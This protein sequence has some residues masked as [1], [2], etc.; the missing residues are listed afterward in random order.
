[1]SKSETEKWI[2]I[3]IE[4]PEELKTA[5]DHIKE[6]KRVVKATLCR[7][8]DEY[9]KFDFEGDF[10]TIFEFFEIFQ[11]VGPNL[12]KNEDFIKE[13]FPLCSGYLFKYLD[14]DMRNSKQLYLTAL[15]YSSKDYIFKLAQNFIKE[16]EI[17]SDLNS[18][19]D[20]V[21]FESFLLNGMIL[22]ETDNDETMSF[23]SEKETIL[24]AL[25]YQPLT[26]KLIN[27]TLKLDNDI[28]LKAI[29]CFDTNFYYIPN[30]LRGNLEIVIAYLKSAVKTEITYSRIFEPTF[31]DSIDFELRNQSDLYIEMIN[32]I[33]NMDLKYLILTEAPIEVQSNDV[34]KAY[35]TN[36]LKLE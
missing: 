12:R 10:V 24:F 32:Q 29:E 2:E 31:W 33:K 21:A 23:L 30:D 15:K 28:A 27:Q 7:P 11:F 13:L 17:Y 35:L 3:V 26:Y 14:P 4:N 18:I 9:I 16:S 36:E 19:L 20:P 22:L 25:E 34:I 1:M 6:D 8:F 5:P